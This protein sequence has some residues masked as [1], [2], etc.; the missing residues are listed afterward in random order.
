MVYMLFVSSLLGLTPHMLHKE[1][2]RSHPQARCVFVVLRCDL[3]PGSAW[4][5]PTAQ[6]PA[7]VLASTSASAPRRM[8]GLC[9][10]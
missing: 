8:P 1:V 6:L 5:S 7:S 10:P 9:A 2:V 4:P 3:R